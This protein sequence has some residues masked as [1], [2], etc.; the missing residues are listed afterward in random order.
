MDALTLIAKIPLIG[1]KIAQK[2]A[3]MAV[4]IGS[5]AVK[6][7]QLENLGKTWSLKKWAVLPYGERLGATPTPA[8][9]HQAAVETLK[10]F[11]LE[12]GGSARRVV[13]SVSG[14]SVLVRNI[15]LSKASPQELR[16]KIRFEAAPFI[17]FPVDDVSMD[18][19]IL[20]EELTGAPGK[21]E[22]TLAAAKK[23]TI[24]EPMSILKEAGLIPVIVD[25]DSFVLETLY[26]E[27]LKA[28]TE[29]LAE[30]EAIIH[31]NLG[32]TYTNMCILWKGRSRLVRDIPIAGNAFTKAL[33]REFQADFATAEEKK[34]KLGLVVT[35]EDKAALQSSGDKA[36]L[37]A[38]A[39]L[40]PRAHDLV[41]EV[42]RSIDFYL[43]RSPGQ[44][45]KKVL[46]S[47]GSANL[48]NIDHY[49]SRE[50]KVPVEFANPFQMID[51]SSDLLTSYNELMPYLAVGCGLGC[52]V[53]GL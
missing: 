48:K 11:L 26:Q 16:K 23:E 21:M 43:S 6:I 51:G 20:E 5:F 36:A 19:T 38:S 31:L 22:I 52:R 29:A 18:F 14:P 8:E 27:I 45:I 34:R 41:T 50:L 46:L 10:Q 7:V 32:A 13:T 9:R 30:T 28:E 37:Q 47:G 42:I 15:Q 35:P 39:A 1:K 24:N 17:P 3:L 49:L 2:H 4:D 53:E 44:T 40:L 12:A 33:Q 25:V